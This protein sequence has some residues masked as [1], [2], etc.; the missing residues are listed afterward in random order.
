MSFKMSKKVSPFKGIPIS[1]T[2]DL[3][4]NPCKNSLYFCNE[5]LT[6]AGSPLLTWF[7]DSSLPVTA[8]RTAGI[9]HQ[10]RVMTEQEAENDLP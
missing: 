5:L 4:F 10:S 8:G 3:G 7:R 9:L 6:F 1:S 2:T